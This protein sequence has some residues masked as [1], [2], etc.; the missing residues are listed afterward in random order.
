MW[1][2]NR[3]WRFRLEACGICPDTLTVIDDRRWAWAWRQLKDFHFRI[4]VQQ[5][6]IAFGQRPPQEVPDSYE[7]SAMITIDSPDPEPKPAFGSTHRGLAKH[8][9]SLRGTW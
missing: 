2:V 3:K 7:R 5:R 8:M 1:T 9:A 6:N 4:G